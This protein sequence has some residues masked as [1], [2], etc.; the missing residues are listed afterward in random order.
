MFYSDCW[1]SLTHD[2][3][4][5]AR[6]A[7]FDAVHPLLQAIGTYAGCYVSLIAGNPEKGNDEGFFTAYAYL[8]PSQ[9]CPSLIHTQVFIGGQETVLQQ[10]IG[11]NGTKR[12]LT[13]E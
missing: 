1:T 6:N 13:L 12:L 3:F 10:R 7:L 9:F 5:R 4:D 11:L 8:P 2:C